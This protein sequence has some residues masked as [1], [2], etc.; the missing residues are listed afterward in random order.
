MPLVQIDLRRGP[1]RTPETPR[2]SGVAAPVD[3][4]DGN[5]SQPLEA[6]ERAV[7]PNSL[8]RAAAGM[9]LAG[10]L[11]LLAPV[12]AAAVTSGNAAVLLTGGLLLLGMLAVLLRP[13][14]AEVDPP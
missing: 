1:A 11:I 13:A 12:A 2:S 3:G 8:G 4:N 5:G 7:P 9:V 14:L 10:G 6:A